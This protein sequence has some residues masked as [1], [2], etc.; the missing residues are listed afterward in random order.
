MNNGAGFTSTAFTSSNDFSITS[1]KCRPAPDLN[2]DGNLDF[3]S[4]FKIFFGDGQGEFLYS[5][6]RIDSIT[7]VADGMPADF[8]NNGTT[9][10][11][12]FR[13]Q[14]QIRYFPGNGHGGFGD[15]I[16]LSSSFSNVIAI[17]DLNG[18]GF[19]DLVLQDALNPANITVLLNPGVTPVSI[20]TAST[21]QISAS[22]A[23]ASTAAPVTLIAS[24]RSLNA[25]SPQAAGSV[26]FTDGATTLGSAPENIYGIAALDFT[27]AA[28]SHST[29]NAAFGGALDPTTNTQ[30]AASSSTNAASVSV[31]PTAPPGAT[32]N[33]ALSTSLSP[34]RELNPVTF[35]ATVTPSVATTFTPPET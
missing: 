26:T 13:V 29:L 12:Q 17:A 4:E 19:S 18:D 32:P 2:A 7:N 25:G 14:P 16:A 30:F 27:L 21:T 31:N 23:T 11:V 20:M 22:A 34:A 6:P 28:G 9:D 5:Q 15:P 10:F 24:V 8:D 33:I 3:L 1:S 35:T